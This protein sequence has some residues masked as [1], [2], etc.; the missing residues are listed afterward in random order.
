MKLLR[1]KP[2]NFQNR[3][4]SV[5]WRTMTAVQAFQQRSQ[6]LAQRIKPATHSF[7]GI[8]GHIK[9]TGVSPAME[10]YEKRKLGIFNQLNFFQLVTGIIVPVAGLLNNQKLPTLAWLVASMPA[11]I[12]IMVLWLN[13]R[14]YYDVALICYFVLYPFATSVVYISGINLG[15]ELSFV[16]YGILSVFFLQEISQ[17]LFAVGLSMVSYFVL[18]VLCKNYTYQL[19]TANTA[20][21]FFNQLLA[22]A[23][24]FYGLFLIKRENTIYQFSILQQKE[25]IAWNEKLLKTQTEE[26]TELNALKNKLF[27]VISHDLKSP[28]YALRNL[29]RN[30]EQYDLPASEIKQMVPEVV[31]ELNYTTS[32]ME[33]LLQWARSQ[34]D[35]DSVKPQLIDISALMTDVWKLLRLQAEA[36]RIRVELKTDATVHV[37]ADKDMI[38][39]VLRNLLSNA[40]KFTP[41]H[42]RISLEVTKLASG[43]K[44][45]VRDTGEG[46][47]AEALEKINLNNYYTTKGT[48]NESGTGLGLLLCKEFLA[49]NGGKMQI[50]SQ[51]GKG[52]VFSFTLPGEE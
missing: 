22:I 40:I 43:A 42:G 13:S 10:D 25:E 28:M 7:L 31:N 19:Q 21:Y 20:F 11:I 16:L 36:K 1:Q 4:R 38:N 26:L 12:P 51:P 8:L 50:D 23:F 49:R 3:V 52:S 39:L 34:M 37:F 29:F 32:L 27:S 30:M 41:D 17:M 18:A 47:S 24:I 35:S 48:A 44:I 46:I 33:N 15:V 45:S 9:E 14:R 2:L 6:Q 5:N